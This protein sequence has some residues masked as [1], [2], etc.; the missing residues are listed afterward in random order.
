MRPTSK[1]LLCL[2][3]SA[4]RRCQA[5]CRHHAK[6][7]YLASWALPREKR[8]AAWVVYAF[9]RVSDDLVDAGG[10]DSTENFGQW[11][12]AVQTAFKSGQSDDPVLSA[13]VRVCRAHGI[14]RRLVFQLLDGL[15][16]DLSTDRYRTQAEL[17]RY[18][19]QVAAV[20]GLMM[21]KVLGCTD[22]RA[23]KHAA[24]LGVAMQLT[25][26]LRDLK[27]DAARGKVYLPAT[28]LDAAGY[29]DSEL[30]AGV[31]SDSFNRLLAQQI[32]RARQLYDSAD[33]GIAFLPFDAQLCV[34]LCSAFYRS[35]LDELSKPGFSPLSGRA[36]V[37]FSKKVQ[38]AVRLLLSP[39]PRGSA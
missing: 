28:E 16:S 30:L 32:R 35:I 2:P 18:C 10:F 21:L 22:K 20:P 29:S 9:S 23:E 37:P 36:V 11:R 17:E 6:S 5:I 15:S 4:V 24:D 14:S 27:E 13:F 1:L 39:V 12:A 19:F 26:I 7:F 3:Q 34:R 38:L 31:P 8:E 33:A 25:N